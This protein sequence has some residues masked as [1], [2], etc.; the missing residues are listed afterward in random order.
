M[1][2]PESLDAAETTIWDRLAKE[3]NPTE[4]EVRDIS[5][6][7]GSMYFIEVTSESFKGKR[8][9]QQQRMVLA[10]LKDLRE[11]WHGIQLKTHVPES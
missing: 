5:G 9:L 2:K 10:T 11:N 1:E 6:G 7:C 8:E 4:L 3:Y